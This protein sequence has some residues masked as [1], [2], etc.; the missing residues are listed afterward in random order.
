MERVGGGPERFFGESEGEFE[1]VVRET[2]GG[3]G[4]GDGERVLGVKVVVGRGMGGEDGVEGGWRRICDGGVG[5][6][7]GW[8]GGR[9]WC[10]S[11]DEIEKETKICI[12][13]TYPRYPSEQQ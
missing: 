13:G 7:E 4:D 6:M 10:M 11:F 12:A 2:G 3:D 5:G 9:G 1:R 8:V